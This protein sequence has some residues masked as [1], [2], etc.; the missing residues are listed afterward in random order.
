MLRAGTATERRAEP[1]ADAPQDSA[2]DHKKQEKPQKLDV[3]FQGSKGLLRGNSAPEEHDQAPEQI[4]KDVR[5]P[6]QGAGE[7]PL[8]LIHI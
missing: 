6:K 5:R 7:H 8:S 1:A 2:D 3:T 4:S